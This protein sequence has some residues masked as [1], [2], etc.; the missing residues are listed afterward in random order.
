MNPSTGAE[1]SM[2]NSGWGCCWGGGMH[3]LTCGSSKPEGWFWSGLGL[4]TS[5][6]WAALETWRRLGMLEE[7]LCLLPYTFHLIPG[8]QV[9]SAVNS[10]CSR[11][12]FTASGSLLCLAVWDREKKR[13]GWVKKPSQGWLGRSS[14]QKRNWGALSFL[15]SNSPSHNNLGIWLLFNTFFGSGVWA[16]V[17]L[18]AQIQ[19]SEESLHL[20]GLYYFFFFQRFYPLMFSYFWE[21]FF[22]KRTL[23]T[24]SQTRNQIVIKQV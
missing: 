17:L 7:F 3:M 23:V 19:L 10:R 2:E 22:F 16:W 6:R 18:L 12:S 5:W 20:D 14:R 24:T 21:V 4:A 8:A 13:K 1:W 11:A 9:G 15:A